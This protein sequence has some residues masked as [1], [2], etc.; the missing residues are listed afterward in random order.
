[1]KS[2][3][4]NVNKK[5][6]TIIC[7]SGL[8]AVAVHQAVADPLELSP[9]E[10]AQLQKYFP[11]SGGDSHYVWNGTPI[12]INLPLQKEKQL[13]FSERVSV[14]VK[15]ALTSDQLKVTN[16]D[17]RVYLQAMATFPS[18]RLYITLLDSHQVI[19][20]DVK[21]DEKADSG[22]TY[23][24]VKQGQSTASNANLTT[25]STGTND[26][27]GVTN[28][29]FNNSST[30]PALSESET[31]VTLVRHAW[32]QLYAPTRLSTPNDG[33]SR[34]PMESDTMLSMLIYGDKVYA[35]PL[36]SWNF[37]S[38]YLTAVQL[39]N[40]YPHATNILI[41]KDLCGDWVAAVTYPRTTLAPAG[42]KSADRTVV[43]LLSNKPFSKAT[44]AC[45][46]RA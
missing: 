11:N 1:M 31:Y 38:T 20:L 2:V 5:L 4:L 24:D 37:N 12:S 3:S 19:M 10:M 22:T 15:G 41:P 7:V 18:T 16:N 13:V 39:I 27:Q 33:V 23:I 14:D 9:T 21:T 45:Y 30:S 26:N 28:S 44:E 43:F 29:S 40:K 8:L 17:K 46:G 34:V 36:A 35:H 25:A 32:Q 42:T 6:I